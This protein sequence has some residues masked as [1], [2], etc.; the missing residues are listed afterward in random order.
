VASHV[1]LFITPPF[2]DRLL[3]DLIAS[4][5]PTLTA[6][7]HRVYEHAFPTPASLPLPV[8]EATSLGHVL[9]SLLPNLRSASSDAEKLG[10]KKERDPEDA[11][12]D[13]MRWGFFALALGTVAI[14][15]R[16]GGLGLGLSLRFQPIDELDSD[17]GGAEG[18]EEAEE[19]AEEMGQ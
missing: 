17:E 16:L 15:L 9:R 14:F 1:L 19:E 3:T 4:Y 7:A 5:Y 12:F 2:P 10:V 11:R 18:A 6:H 13:R 8:V